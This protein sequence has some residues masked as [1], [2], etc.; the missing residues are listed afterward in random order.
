MLI[1]YLFVAVVFLSTCK[2]PNF[3]GVCHPGSKGFL[4]I[5]IA[6]AILRD[7]SLFC[8]I[9]S[10]SGNGSGITPAQPVILNLKAKSI[11]QTGFLVGTA[12][13]NTAT[14]EISVDNGNFAQA[15]GT[16]SWKFLLPSGSNTWKDAS[17][18]HSI[19]VRAKNS[20]GT[21]SSTVTI[22]QIS[23]GNNR[24]LNGDGYEDLVI[25]APSYSSNAGRVYVYYSKNTF[26]TTPA[27]ATS[28]DLILTSESAGSYFGF[29]P[30]L[31]DINGDGYADLAVGAFNFPPTNSGKAYFFYSS[32]TNGIGT[33]TLSG[34]TA[35]TSILGLA[36]NDSLGVSISL[37]DVNGDGY[38]DAFIGATGI[39]SG[40]IFHSSGNTGLSLTTPSSANRT[41]TG[42]ANSGF[43]Y[44]SRIADI[45][46]DGFADLIVTAPNHLASGGPPTFRGK[47]HFYY[48]LGTS[49]IPAADNANLTGAMDSD[50]LGA[51]AVGDVNGDG[52]LD[53]A[54]GAHG[55]SGSGYVCIFHSTGTG[56]IGSGVLTTGSANTLITAQ[57]AN[58]KFGGFIS[59]GDVNGDGYMDL[60]I[61]AYA[62]PGGANTGRIYIFQSAGSTG[63]GTG[64]IGGGT[65]NRI[66][67]GITG[68]DSFGNYSMLRDANGDGFADVW[69]SAPG[70]NGGAN[71][72]R[73]YVFHSNGTQI[74]ATTTSS[75]NTTIDGEAGA[76]QYGTYGY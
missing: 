51:I 74:S 19:S 60:A 46:G 36:A 45:T 37:G 71:Q 3:E 7:T 42:V 72:G 4:N 65:A 9:R 15:T 26:I 25:S 48:S 50:A 11:L 47:A 20:Q 13:S 16:T 17:N 56:G 62:Y 38:A 64:S 10:V 69:I 63:Y 58:D 41:L 57:T 2:G 76:H 66:L 31:G 44:F 53:V 67:T 43:S 61:G 28:A 35:S 40:Y 1:K 12:D 52:I 23:K 34:S 29:S 49:G 54:I 21:T 5:V 8:G 33:G 14:V 18:N 27:S 24:D 59:M 75:A 68:N 30:V 6:K 70:Y 73:I 32:G 22:T 39:N 55:G